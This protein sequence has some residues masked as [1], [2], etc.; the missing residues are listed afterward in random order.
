MS[1][2]L[3]VLKELRLF[4]SLLITTGMVSFINVDMTLDYIDTYNIHLAILTI[5]GIYINHFLSNKRHKLS[6][7]RLDIY[8]KQLSGVILD[9]SIGQIKA[10]VRQAFKDYSKVEVIDFITTIH[11]LR[12]LDERRIELGVNSYTE[13]MM[14]ILL[15]K[16]QV[17]IP[18]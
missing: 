4:I 5:I 16:I 15:N 3:A 17:R 13:E 1:N 10:E 14:S 9:N 18:Q 11:Y 7:V 12:G 2:I 6:E 8:Q